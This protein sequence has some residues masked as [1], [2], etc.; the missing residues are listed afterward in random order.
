MLRVLWEGGRT[1]SVRRKILCVPCCLERNRVL[2]ATVLQIMITRLLLPVSSLTFCY[3][4]LSLH[5]ASFDLL[6]SRLPSL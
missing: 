2:D 4:I 3:F 6:P 1:G 5:E